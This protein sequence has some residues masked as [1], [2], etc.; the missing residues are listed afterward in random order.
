[1]FEQNLQE[2]KNGIKYHKRNR[3]DLIKYY[4]NKRL[5]DTLITYFK[6]L[7]SSV[8]ALS[9]VDPEKVMKEI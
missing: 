7:S 8:Y 1:M 5:N 9:I 3:K 2:I 4:I 6:V